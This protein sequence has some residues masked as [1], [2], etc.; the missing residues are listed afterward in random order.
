MYKVG[1]INLTIEMVLIKIHNVLNSFSNKLYID[2]F[3][4]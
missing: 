3:Y 2:K 4:L 1:L